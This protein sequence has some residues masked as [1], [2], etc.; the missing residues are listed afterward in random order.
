MRQRQNLPEI[1]LLEQRWSSLHSERSSWFA[2]WKDISQNIL[3]RNGKFFE[4]DTNRGRNKYNQIIDNTATRALKTLGAGMMAGATSPARPWFRLSTID[5]SLAKYHPV[6]LW[7]EEITQIMAGIF[8]RSNTYRT[9]HM[10]YEELGCF[11]TSAS[12]CLFDYET[13]IH[14]Y[15]ST[16]GEYCISTNAKGEVDTFYREFQMTVSQLVAE[17]GFDNC[18]LSVQSSWNTGSLDEWITVIHSV[19]PR[20]DRDYSKTDNK[21][22]PFKSC[23]FEKGNNRSKEEDGKYLRESGYKRFPVLAPRWSVSGGDIYGHSPGMEALGDVRQLKQEQ[24]RKGQAI[25]YQ[26]NPPIVAPNSM[27]NRDMQRFPGGVTFAD[28]NQ[29]QK[30]ESMFDVNLRLDYLLEDIRDVR[31]R[32][33]ST[34]Y[35][36]L[37]LMLANATDTRM[38]ATEVA[39]R[40]EE[41]LL[42]LGPTLERLHNE[43]LSPLI[44]ITLSHMFDNGLVPPPPEEMDGQE[45][46]VEYVSMLA[47]AQKAI[48]ANS[49]DRWIIGVTNIAQVKPEARDKVNADYYVDAYADILG[50][51]PNLIHG[52]EEV[53]L[54]RQS[55]AEA[56][57]AQAEIEAHHRQSETARN[58][59]SANTGGDTNALMDVMNQFSGYNSPSPLEV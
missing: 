59:A 56:E 17:F 51:D 32:I 41:K 21:N 28:L 26:T 11:G 4:N 1:Q 58:L 14:H 45:I 15:P 5:P 40:H 42:M 31:Q 10:M 22:M 33:Q 37:F 57:A 50:V 9:L 23:Y 7:L 34:F 12:I 16:I 29:S 19:E 13:I 53:A 27:K 25:D 35:A 46:N 55:R 24:I 39:E 48:G 52:N 43:L 47:Q 30:I 20:S 2:H 36:D 49:I 18:S 54:V 3:P 6:K 38:T 44:E 8:T